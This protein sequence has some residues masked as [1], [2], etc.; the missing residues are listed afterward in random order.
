MYASSAIVLTSLGLGLC[1]LAI[2]TATSVNATVH[3]RTTIFLSSDLLVLGY[4]YVP[5]NLTLAPPVG[6]KSASIS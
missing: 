4:W 5:Q 1:A 3:G 6:A 2:E